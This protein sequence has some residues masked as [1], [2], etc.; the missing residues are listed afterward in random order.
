MKSFMRVWL[1]IGVIAVGLGIGLL[2]IAFIS[3]ARWENAWEEQADFTTLDQSYQGVEKLNVDIGYG[4]VRIVNGDKFSISAENILEGEL[5]SY[6]ENGT[7]YIRE[8]NHHDSHIFG[9]HF[10]LRRVL[11]WDHEFTPK[12]T[13][14]LPEGFVAEEADLKVGA[15][16]LKADELNAVEG[17]FKVD[18]GEMNIEK[19]SVSEKSEYNVGTGEMTLQNTDINDITVDCGVGYVRIDG[20]V[21]GENSIKCGI[22]NVE[23]LLNGDNRDYNYDVT[24]GIGQVDIDGRN[25]SNISGKYTS[26]DSADSSLNLDC[27]IGKISVDFH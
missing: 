19:L 15:G 2:I 18:A 23:L 9:M 5:E 20:S 6:V 26:N 24:C 3:G 22:G 1:G 13:V 4:E 8:D 25:Y 27:G 11:S 12:I 14:I 21:A 17:E 7:W 10:P 16:T